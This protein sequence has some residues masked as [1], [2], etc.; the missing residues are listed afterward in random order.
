MFSPQG[1]P[2]LKPRFTEDAEEV[3]LDLAPDELAPWEPGHPVTAR[4][5]STPPGLAVHTPAL[6]RSDQRLLLVAA[7]RP[8]TPQ[9]VRRDR[10]R[11]G[12]VGVAR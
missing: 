11:R 7:R 2:K 9:P 4:P 8:V 5:L 6:R 12:P 1:V 3:V 10:H